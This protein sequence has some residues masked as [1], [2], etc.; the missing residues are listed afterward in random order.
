M[1]YDLT[2]PSCL[3]ARFQVAV[4]CGRNKKLLSDLKSTQWPGGSHVVACGFVDNIHE[5]RCS[6]M[7]DLSGFEHRTHGTMA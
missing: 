3:S 5:V 7:L 1:M 2:A 4:I 6:F